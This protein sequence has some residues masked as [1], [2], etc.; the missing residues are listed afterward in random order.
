ML[1]HGDGQ[2]APEIL[3]H[4]YHPLVAGKADAVFGSRMMNDFG[5]PLK[6]GMPWYKFVGN[7]VLTIF[8]NWSL[9]MNLTEFHSGYRAYNLHA[10][11]EIDFSHMTG[12]FHFDTE[13]IIKLHHQNFKILEI[14]IPTFYGSEICYVNGLAY[15]HDVARAVWHYKQCIRSVARHPEFEE[16]FV[17]YPIKRLKNSSHSVI[18]ALAGSGNSI[19]QIGCGT[20]L[21]AADLAAQN[22][23]VAGVDVLPAS[24]ILFSIQRYVQADPEKGPSSFSRTG[25]RSPLRPHPA[26]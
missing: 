17:Q 21:F 16:Y 14:P 11:R 2:Y 10:L 3:A 22:N 15:A 9:G 5:G 12:N 26:A 4:L 25:S 6:G 8:E 13:I 1:L 19:L 23:Q 7:R 20:G 18:Q 24:E